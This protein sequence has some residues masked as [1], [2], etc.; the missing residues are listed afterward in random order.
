[1]LRFQAVFILNNQNER[2]APC[3]TSVEWRS[4]NPDPVHPV[5]AH[6]A[7]RQHLRI[8]A[9]QRLGQHV[10]LHLPIDIF[11][12]DRLAA[13]APR[14]HVVDRTGKFEA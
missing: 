10:E 12:V 4:A 11:A 8:E 3:S 9:I 6:L 14:S 1:M 7:P 2:S 5:V 13:V